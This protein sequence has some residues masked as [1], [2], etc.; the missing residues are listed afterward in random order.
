MLQLYEQSLRSILILYPPIS[1]LLLHLISFVRAPTIA[2]DLW[3]FAFSYRCSHIS[4]EY[5][6]AILVETV[7]RVHC[8]VT[9]CL[10]FPLRLVERHRSCVH[11]SCRQFEGYSESPLAIN[12]KVEQ[13]RGSPSFLLPLERREPPCI[14]PQ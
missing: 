8:F 14:V 12:R 3:F 10:L 7:V 9:R 5:V 4:H 2:N 6:N 11:Q 1:M 13:M